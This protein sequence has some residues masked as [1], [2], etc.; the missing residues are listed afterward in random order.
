LLFLIAALAV[1]SNQTPPQNPTVKSGKYVV[2]LRVPTEGLYAGEEIDIE[3]RVM[4]S[5]KN[6]EILG[7]AGVPNVKAEGVITMPSMPG[8]PEVK[9]KI[10]AEGV[11]GDYG[12]EAFFPHGGDYKIDLRLTPANE[13]PF[14]ASFTVDVADEKPAKNRP[15]PYGLTVVDGKGAVVG[16]PFNLKLQVKE[17]KTKAT[18]TKFDMAH[19]KYFHLLIASKDFEWFLHEHPEMAPDGTWS[20][21]V[22][23]P[24]G[25]EY[26]IYG[27]VAPVGK[28]S[29]I[30]AASLKVTGPRPAWK[31]SWAPKSTG[32]DQGVNGVFGG[33][34]VIGK[35]TIL[36]VKLTDASGKPVGD[37]QPWLG[38]AGHLMIFSQDGQTVVHSHPADGEENERLVKEGELRFTGRFPKAGLYRVFVQFQRNGRIHTIPC[39][40]S[41][42]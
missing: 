6:D 13:A 17:T 11:P 25:G 9:P 34:L 18:V 41:V 2:E 22:D 14:K 23:F 3:F 31:V 15:R 29:Q 20:V 1:S 32:S 36:T 27:D 5:S 35:K 33:E 7:M 40:T 16:K 10:H 42:K 38:A 39:T 26:W 12:I 30:T 37:T 8:M 28:G 4:D 24:A 19:E 21:N